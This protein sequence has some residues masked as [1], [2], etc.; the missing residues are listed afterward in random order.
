MHEKYLEEI[1]DEKL[2]PDNT[3]M[4]NVYS[5]KKDTK[6]E[7]VNAT[8]YKKSIGSLDT[9]ATLDMIFSKSVG[10]VR[11]FM[12]KPRSCNPHAT[13]IILRYIKGTAFAD[14]GVLMPNQKNT[15]R[16]V[17]WQNKV[18]QVSQISHAYD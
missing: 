16:D 4:E 12:E 13:K 18:M 3:P 11:K 5:W 14:H 1:Q 2:Q 10:L 6:Y 17:W 9:Y 15:R 8:L 7:L